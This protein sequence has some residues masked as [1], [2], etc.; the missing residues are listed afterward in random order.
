MFTVKVEVE[1]PDTLYFYLG[2]V[3]VYL[4][5]FMC[6]NVTLNFGRHFNILAPFMV[7]VTYE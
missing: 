4:G 6:K 7:W 5:L 2:A 3:L 1:Y